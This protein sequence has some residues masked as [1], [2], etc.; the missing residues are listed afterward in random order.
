M[1]MPFDPVVYAE[2]SEYFYLPAGGDPDPPV[3]TV[4][5]NTTEE[6]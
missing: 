5:E 1:Q 4:M 2:P 3:H 6:V